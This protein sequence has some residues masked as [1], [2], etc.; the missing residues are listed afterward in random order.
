MKTI[1]LRF[2]AFLVPEKELSAKLVFDNIRNYLICAAFLAL[3]N[4][5]QRGAANVPSAVVD[6]K[7][8]EH[9]QPFAVLS[10]AAGTVLL[11]LNALQPMKLVRRGVGALTGGLKVLT[12]RIASHENIAVSF[13]ALFVLIAFMICFVVFAFLFSLAAFTVITYLVT[14]SAVGRGA[15]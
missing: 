15:L 1:L 9:L 5:L 4:W 3:T 10:L 11:V 14:F 13:L 12:E 2:A 8:L 7:F 6:R